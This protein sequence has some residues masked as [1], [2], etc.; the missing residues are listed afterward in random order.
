MA[1][2]YLI[3]CFTVV[4]LIGVSSIHADEKIANPRLISQ[5][6]FSRSDTPKKFDLPLKAMDID[7]NVAG[8]V[9]ETTITLTFFNPERDELEGQIQLQMPQ[10]SIVSG[11]A[12]DINGALRDAVIVEGETAQM[13]YEDIKRRGVD[14]GLATLIRPDLFN[15]LVYPLPAETTR[16]IRIKFISRVKQRKNFTIP[17]HLNEPVE[18]IT[19]KANFQGHRSKPS[20]SIDA[21]EITMKGPKKGLYSAATSLKNTR[22]ENGIKLNLTK[23]RKSSSLY[24]HSNGTRYFEIFERLPKT[25]S[26]KIKKTKN[27]RLYYDASWSRQHTNKAAEVALINDVI[28][29][30]KPTQIELISLGGKSDRHSLVLNKKSNDLLKSVNSWLDDVTFTN[31]SKLENAFAND[32]APADICLLFTDANYKF[33]ASNITLPNCQLHVI[34]ST[35][36]T[37]RLYGLWL[38]E[39]GGGAFHYLTQDNQAE[40]TSAIQRPSYQLRTIHIAGG[41][42][43]NIASMNTKDGYQHII[44]TLSG[45]YATVTLGYGAGHRATQHKRYRFG[46]QKPLN[47]DGIAPLWAAKKI[48]R[49]R[50]APRI[51]YDEIVKLSQKEGV[52]TPETAFLVLEE[53]EDYIDFNIRP[54]ETEPE[55]RKEYDNALLE[56]SEEIAEARTDYIETIQS[57]WDA[58]VEWHNTPKSVFHERAERRKQ[59]RLERERRWAEE[60]ARH[61]NDP[62]SQSHTY[63]EDEFEEMVVTGSRIT[64]SDLPNRPQT[65]IK[66][67]TPDRPYLRIL[68]ETPITNWP[69][70]LLA[71]QV[72]YGDNSIFYFDVANFLMQENQ[73]PLAVSF[74]LNVLELDALDS[75]TLLQL[76]ETLVD[77]GATYIALP[78]FDRVIAQAPKNLKHPHRKY[79]LAHMRIAERAKDKATKIKHYKKALDILST[80][81]VKPMG[82]YNEGDGTEIAMLVEANNI[83]S[84]LNDLGQSVPSFKQSLIHNMDADI[85]LVLDWNTAATDMDIWVIEPSGEKAYYGNKQT[86]IGGQMSNDITSGY[87]P[88]FYLLKSAPTGTWKIYVDYFGSDIIRANGPV[89]ITAWVCINYGRVNEKCDKAYTELTDDEQ[90]EY[91]IATVTFEAPDNVATT[92]SA[93][94]QQ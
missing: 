64:H 43:D 54:P 20:L 33:E 56:Y 25:K 80:L 45:K 6:P 28:H 29:E 18:D 66:P 94:P 90:E 42:A 3:S 79:A 61:Q 49:A 53:Y 26:R 47:F 65:I 5:E 23:P 76:A 17:F 92:E 68:K 59:A 81:I 93:S 62:S 89:S 31:N 73:Q 85:R 19:I 55:L 9:V 51:D 14:P 21:H 36:N 4:C 58:L 91:F 7:I 15:N 67:W 37:N 40:I 44:G 63:D 22:I 70:K 16:S 35:S 84:K 34:S 77:Y 27:M 32:N 8:Q 1:F 69:L 46:T 52:L 38:A 41:E 13:V 50:I 10:G 24:Q 78:L 86:N 57:D 30:L 12:L 71:L 39:E 60:R 74:V 88:E 72:E 11:Y 48:D 75:I 82:H 87:G 83:I 2:R